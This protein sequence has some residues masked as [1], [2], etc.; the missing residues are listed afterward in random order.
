MAT[1]DGLTGRYYYFFVR[2]RNAS[3][4]SG[5]A[6]LPVSY[7]APEF[8]EPVLDQTYTAGRPIPTL[9]LPEATGRDV[10]MTYSISPDLP[11]GLT[12][13]ATARTITGT[14][15]AVSAAT[16]YTYTATDASTDPDRDRL[17]FSIT[18]ADGPVDLVPAFPPG[19]TIED[20]S[21][22]VGRAVATLR[23]PAAA[24]GDGML[25]YSLTPDLPS[26]LS[27]DASARTISGTPTVE[28]TGTTYTYTATDSD[29][30][31][32]D[33]AT[34]RFTITVGPGD[35]VPVFPSTVA[36]QTHTVGQAIATLHLPEATGGDGTLTY[37]ITPALPAGLTF[38]PM[39]LTITGTPTA[40][41]A[42]TTHTYTV[43]DSDATNPDSD[44]LR[45]TITVVETLP[46]PGRPMGLSETK[47]SNER[48]ALDW[49]DAAYA[50]GYELMVW[51]QSIG[52][53]P[54]PAAPFTLTCSGLDPAATNPVCADS[55]AT[56][57]GLTDRSYYFFINSRN[58]SGNV[59][60]V[61]GAARLIRGAGVPGAGP[62][63]DVRGGTAHPHAATP[64]GHRQGPA[65]DV[66]HLTGPACRADVRRY[67]AHDHGHAH[68]RLR[69][70]DVHLL[71]DGRFHRPRQGQ[72]HLL[73]HG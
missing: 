5:W 32:P 15:T 47:L 48:V 34:L 67:G 65:D 4:P 16:T 61:V 37:S 68:C 41:T 70:H 58:A 66:Q 31:N 30:V 12:F 21:Y 2:S 42:E 55:R 6:T 1:V 18:I 54:L 9:Q 62:G 44:T 45:F 50:A 38:D 22:R 19:A 26:G 23:L 25:R 52:W 33:S 24:G 17:T 64:R 56:I 28:S 59:Q 36:D 69:H 71:G 43:T 11:A 57:D 60:V 20:Q 39:A 35:S 10:P 63:S 27:F 29:A 49:D 3:G 14:P 8:L 46:P 40:I 51:N 72:A 13:D 7:E 53:T 73:H